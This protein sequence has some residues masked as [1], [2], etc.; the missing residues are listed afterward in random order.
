MLHSSESLNIMLHFIEFQKLKFIHYSNCFKFE[1][2]F[3]KD[4]N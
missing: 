1:N 3:L 4:Y 2:Y